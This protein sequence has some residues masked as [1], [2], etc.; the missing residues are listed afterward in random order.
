MIPNPIRV[1]LLAE[2]KDGRHP[3]SLT[4]WGG[5]SQ[6]PQFEGSRSP[7]ER[8]N[9]NATHGIFAI[10]VNSLIGRFCLPASGGFSA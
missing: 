4:Y 7:Q 8:R 6:M 1:K 9:P 10:K 5:R 3:L 2:P